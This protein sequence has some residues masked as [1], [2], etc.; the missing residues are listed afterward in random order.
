MTFSAI[1]QGKASY[2]PAT[3]MQMAGQEG[4]DDRVIG[5]SLTSG[6]VLF[7][8]NQCVCDLLGTP[9][10][11]I[12]LSSV[13]IMSLDDIGFHNNQCDC[14]LDLISGYDLV[15]FPVFLFGLSVRMSDNRMKEG[16]FNALISAFSWGLF[17]N[18]ATDNQATHCLI[19]RDAA[20][21]NRTVNKH[22]IIFID[23]TATSFCERFL[24]LAKG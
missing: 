13:L 1:S 22:N 20:L 18:T 7:N 5:R 24:N 23:P 3:A 16:L 4:L 11:N 9:V 21:P 15:L 19:I 8:D 14:N 12:V 17:M 10:T 6:K 2:D